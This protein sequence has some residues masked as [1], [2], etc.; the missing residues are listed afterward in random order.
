MVNVKVVSVKDIVKYTVRITI[1][2]L[3]VMGAVK[4]ISNMDIKKQEKELESQ[5]SASAEK[6]KT[7]PM[8]SC[9]STTYTAMGMKEKEQEEEK[10]TTGEVDNSH[11]EKILNMELRY[12]TNHKK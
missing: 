10:Q 8:L 4:Y 11:I 1:V 3:I 12:V 5:I 6:L 9:F 2:L 7:N